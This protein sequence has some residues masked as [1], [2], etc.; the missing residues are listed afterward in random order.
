MHKGESRKALSAAILIAVGVLTGIIITV[1]AL[2][3]LNAGQ[4][5]GVAVEPTIETQAPLKEEA[6]VA[7]TANI[8]QPALANQLAPGTC[9]SQTTSGY[10]IVTGSRAID[11]PGVQVVESGQPVVINEQGSIVSLESQPV[12]RNG[13]LS[14]PPVDPPSSKGRAYT[15]NGYY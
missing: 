1:L 3:L 15:Q 5:A 14:N 4:N 13:L 7:A 2:P 9:V 8:S 6:S 12:G 10:S 11:S